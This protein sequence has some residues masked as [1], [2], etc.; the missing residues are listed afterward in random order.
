MAVGAGS[1]KRASKKSAE[2]KKTTATR[3]ST[4]TTAPTQ[5]NTVN[6]VYHIGEKLPIYLL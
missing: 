6:Q 2:T 1:I 3:A 5:Q 4:K